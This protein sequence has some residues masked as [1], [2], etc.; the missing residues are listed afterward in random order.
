MKAE[1][2]TCKNCGGTL[3]EPE[4]SAGQ[5]I[6]RCSFCNSIF[7][8]EPESEFGKDDLPIA[9]IPENFRIDE[10]GNDL[11]I[12]W[13]WFRFYHVFLLFFSIS[14]IAM[15]SIFLRMELGL[16]GS[17]FSLTFFFSL[18]FIAV[19]VALFYTS[20]CGFFNST[21]L[22]V[23]KERLR[24]SHGPQPWLPS[25]NILPQDIMQF[26][27][28]ENV[29]RSDKSTSYSYVLYVVLVSGKHVKLVSFDEYDQAHFLERKME[30]FL[31]I[32]DRRVHGEYV[33][34]EIIQF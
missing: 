15:I 5:R 26:Y 13:K 24:I 14:W 21:T 3:K 29:S 18:P 28:R 9:A 31:N 6:A 20:I 16:S 12:S 33:P 17:V 4:I 22:S 2:L 19:G 27:C 1:A 10:T 25:Q 8:L 23:T 11:R 7:F 30:K 34:Q 32:R